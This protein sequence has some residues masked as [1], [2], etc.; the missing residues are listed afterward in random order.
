[1]VNKGRSLV[2]YYGPQTKVQDWLSSVPD[3]NE[4]QQRALEKA[5]AQSVRY[6]TTNNT[7]ISAG[8]PVPSHWPKGHWVNF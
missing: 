6:A 2:P 7:C 4:L 3:Q 5:R 8:E 1:M